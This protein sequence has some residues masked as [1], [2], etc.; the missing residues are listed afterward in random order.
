MV[1][2]I[3]LPQ[4]VAAG[5]LAT[6][7]PNQCLLQTPLRRTWPLRFL[8]L[9]PE[10]PRASSELICRC[11]LPECGWRCTPPNKA[12]KGEASKLLSGCGKTGQQCPSYRIASGK[13]CA[14][15]GQTSTSC[16]GTRCPHAALAT[17]S[18]SWKTSETAPA[19]QPLPSSRL[20]QHSRPQ[21]Q[22][23]ILLLCGPSQVRQDR[24]QQLVQ[25]LLGRSARH[26]ISACNMD[27]SAGPLIT[28][29]MYGCCSCPR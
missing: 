15:C 29:I 28:T 14:D 24:H 13:S 3:L 8:P 20:G 27:C 7:S 1:K 9:L 22:V 6:P 26:C 19:A 4:P 5:G 25:C 23:C 16:L 17:T 12:A 10:V 11:G 2:L 21:S 18:K